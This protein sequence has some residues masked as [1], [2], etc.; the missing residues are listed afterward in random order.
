MSKRQKVGDA[1]EAYLPGPETGESVRGPAVM[2]TS[3]AA[4]SVDKGDSL[5]P[6]TIQVSNS[7]RKALEELAAREDRSLG[8]IVRAALSEYLARH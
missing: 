5:G 7:Q 2:P 3:L 6:L 8:W 4:T 1:L